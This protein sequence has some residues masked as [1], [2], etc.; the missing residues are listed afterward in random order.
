MSGFRETVRP[1][2]TLFAGRRI[3]LLGGSFNPAHGGHR[4]ISDAAL[5][6]LALDEVWWLVSPQNP[7]KPAAGMAPFSARLAGAAAASARHRKIRVTGVEAALGTHYTADTL[8]RLVAR[9]PA[10]RFVWLMGADN[11][12]QLP[13]WHRWP[14]IFNT[15]VIAVFAR[16]PYVSIALAGKAA[17]RF[18]AMRVSAERAG[19]LAARTPPAWTYIALRPHPATATELRAAGE[20]RRMS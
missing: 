12:V 19:T 7:L 9:F 3:G 15:A 16:Q 11:L 20:R 1:G 18:R 4:Y 10:T 14:A 13:R 2:S 6:R 5:A 17:A 8:T